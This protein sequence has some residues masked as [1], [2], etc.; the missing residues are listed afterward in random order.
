MH[1]RILETI[2]LVL[3]EGLTEALGTGRY[4]R[5]EGATRLPQREPVAPDHDGSR[6]AGVGCPAWSDRRAY[7]IWAR[8]PQPGAPPLMHA[9]RVSAVVI[10][11]SKFEINPST[12]KAALKAP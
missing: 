1:R 10:G 4:E 12:W 5:G 8:I 7:G 11:W 6:D 9:R 3:K 2:E